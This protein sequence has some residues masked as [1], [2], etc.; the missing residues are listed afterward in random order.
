V[1]IYEIRPRGHAKLKGQDKAATR[2]NDF[3]VILLWRPITLR[4][5]ED[6]GDMFSETSVLT[7]EY[8]FKVAEG[9]NNWY[10][11]K[12]IPQMT[13]IFN[14][15]RNW[16]CV[17]TVDCLTKSVGVLHALH[18]RRWTSSMILSP[19]ANYTDWST[20]TCRR[21]LVPTF[22]D[23]D[24]SRGQRGGTPTVVNLSFLDRSRYFSFK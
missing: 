13:V 16:C 19:Q 10:R 8:M 7:R 20:A 11:R 3:T 17:Y 9:I 2:N 5:H 18:L 1:C 4:N 14:P 15:K 22:A 21:N 23:R 12:S 6:G 24:L